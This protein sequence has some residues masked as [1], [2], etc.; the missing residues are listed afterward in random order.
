MVFIFVYILDKFSALAIVG[1]SIY[2]LFYKLFSA[3]RKH[4][5]V[6]VEMTV[7]VKSLRNFT[8]VSSPSRVALADPVV[9]LPIAWT[10]VEAPLGGTRYAKVWTLQF[11]VLGLS[12]DSPFVLSC[13]VDLSLVSTLYG[14]QVSLMFL[15]NF[16][17]S[18]TQTNC[19]TALSWMLSSDI[20]NLLHMTGSVLISSKW[21]WWG[22]EL[23]PVCALSVAV[24]CFIGTEIHAF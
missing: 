24:S 10:A 8:A 23:V 20:R 16:C 18:R 17:G 6:A 22:V 19:F 13:I 7:W 1:D 11:P 12:Y 21:V 14:Q 4:E 3:Y 2:L 5:T 15:V 9:T